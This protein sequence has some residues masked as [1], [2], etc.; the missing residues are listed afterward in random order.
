MLS[1]SEVVCGERLATS[2]NSFSTSLP[3]VPWTR[4]SWRSGGGSMKV[5]A[6]ASAA[7][8]D[9]VYKARLL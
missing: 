6:L 3:C 4:L 2:V 1:N 7:P 8:D 5:R 9:C